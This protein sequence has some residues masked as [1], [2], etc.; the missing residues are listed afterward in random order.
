MPGTLR[1]PERSPRSWP[2]PSMSGSRS[3]LRIAPPH[4]ERAHAL[5]AVDLVRGDRHQVDAGLAHVEAAPCPSACTASVWT[6]T[7]RSCAIGRDLRHRLQH[8][9]LVVRGHD[10]DEDRA[11]VMAPRSASRST[12]PSRP[13]PRYV[14]PKPSAV[15]CLQLSRT[16]L[17]SVATR[18]DVAALVFQRVR[19]ALDREVV[20]L[21]RAA[22]EDDLFRRCADQRARPAAAPPRPRHRP[23]SRTRVSGWRRCRSGREKYGS[24]ASSTR[25]VDR[26]AGVEV[27]IDGNF[28]DMDRLTR[29]SGCQVADCGSRTVAQT[30]QLD[31]NPVNLA[32]V[33]RANPRHGTSGQYFGWLGSTWS[34]HARMPPF[35][36]LTFLNPCSRRKAAARALRMPDLH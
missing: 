11:S 19:H 8:A 26:R 16:A 24:I 25:A 22:G 5:G 9:N 6:S 36:F 21:G 28:R 1:V 27:Q 18:D 4:V 12:S 30:R 17:C 14:T 34:T 20:R 3:I 10:A 35:R 31:A 15:R 32:T 33:N 2:P 29:L 13:T 7:P 23:S